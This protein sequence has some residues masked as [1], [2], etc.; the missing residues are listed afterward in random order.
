MA[1][2]LTPIHQ[3]PY[4]DGTERV[5]DGD[6]AMGALAVAT[7]RE[8]EELAKPPGVI[9]S[10]PSM[11][12]QGSASP[13]K[14]QLNAVLLGPAA[15]FSDANDWVVVPAGTPDGMY[16]IELFMTMSNV[17]STQV[18][19]SAQIWYGSSGAPA[20]IA[21]QSV[22]GQGANLVYVTVNVTVRLQA[23]QIVAAYFTNPVAD[24]GDWSVQRLSVR[25]I[26]D[27]FA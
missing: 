1:T 12:G 16:E 5:M 17:A 26:A 27:V 3:L 4:P 24:V 2:I 6:N 21:A 11:T 23:G 10:G 9:V 13:I 25:R 18:G 7:D 14:A 22:T 15:W 19:L 8:L 20:L